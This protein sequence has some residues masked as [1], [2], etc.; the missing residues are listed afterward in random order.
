MKYL[1]KTVQWQL[2]S[3]WTELHDVDQVRSVIRETCIENPMSGINLNGSTWIE[4][5]PKWSRGTKNISLRWSIY[6]CKKRQETKFEAC[7]CSEDYREDG[8]RFK[9]RW[10]VGL[11]KN[12]EDT[13]DSMMSV[14]QKLKEPVRLSVQ[15][16]K[17]I[18]RYIFPIYDTERCWKYEE[19]Y[20]FR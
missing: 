4:A 11:A 20:C 15:I 1:K 19:E 14:V 16:W 9:R 18:L 5:F 2:Y 8:S 3:N 7:T 6:L 12:A 13:L 17:R 10:Y